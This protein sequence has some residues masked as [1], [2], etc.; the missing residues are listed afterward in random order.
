MSGERLLESVEGLECDGSVG[1]VR[2]KRLDLDLVRRGLD[3]M[4]LL[5][6]GGTFVLK[7]DWH[8]SLQLHPKRDVDSANT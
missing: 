3:E 1:P 8:C 4:L 6:I 5:L 2:Q 7:L